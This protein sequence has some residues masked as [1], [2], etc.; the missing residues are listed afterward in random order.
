MPCDSSLMARFAAATA[1][2]STVSL[3]E[4]DEG[5]VSVWKI[6]NNMEKRVFEVEMAMIRRE[7]GYANGFLVPAPHNPNAVPNAE[8]P[9]APPTST[10]KGKKGP[11]T[12][13]TTNAEKGK[14][15][16]NGG[17]GGKKV[18][19]HQRKGAKT[20]KTAKAGASRASP[21]TPSSESESWSSPPT[22]I[23]P[24]ADREAYEK[25]QFI[26]GRSDRQ[27]P[28]RV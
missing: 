5:M 24:E 19:A 18:L 9:P 6:L 12:T 25:R 10:N 23:M 20:K 4:Y 3:A 28:G 22:P 17:N 13:T 26:Y 14:G 7:F 21:P 1:T 2:A 16:G 27:V 8:T 15:N 11:T